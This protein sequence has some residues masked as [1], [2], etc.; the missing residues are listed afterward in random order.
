MLEH[1]LGESARAIRWYS[2]WSSHRALR[3]LRV[4]LVVTVVAVCSW[5]IWKQAS[6]GYQTVLMAG[7]RIPPWRILASWLCT[8]AATALGAWE[9]VLLVHALGGEL[10]L[11]RGISV[12]LTSMLSKYLPGAIWPYAGKAYL[13]TR[14]GV[15]AGIASLSVVGEFGI[16]HFAGVLTMILSLPFSDFVRASAPERVALQAIA[17]AI[18]MI[19]IL[20]VAVLGKRWAPSKKNAAGADLAWQPNW[21]RVALVL[22]AVLATWWLLGLGFSILYGPSTSPWWQHLARYTFVL[23]AGLLL[24]RI[25][26]F[27]PTGL[28]LREA[29]IV[30]LLASSSDATLVVVLAIIFRLEML[31]GEILS[32]LVAV[33]INWISRPGED[34]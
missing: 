1:L 20:A 31:A 21:S 10:E 25:A 7:L 26:F 14:E 15:T 28:G 16:V 32:A 3:F 8:A 29:I 24:G 5:F 4:A 18:T 13:T 22:A 27:L 6:G 33:S 12:H 30:A 11:T 23:A 19:S 34:E 2:S 17:I 9:W